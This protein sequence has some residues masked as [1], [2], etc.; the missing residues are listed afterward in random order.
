MNI[1]IDSL[2][3]L[4]HQIILNGPGLGNGF[5]HFA[6]NINFLID[7]FALNPQ[8]HEINAGQGKAEKESKENQIAKQTK[9][10][11]QKH[12]VSVNWKSVGKIGRQFHEREA[13]E[14]GAEKEQ[15][16]EKKVFR[17]KEV[18]V[19]NLQG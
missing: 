10:K 13:K 9:Q 2:G 3:V 11:E 7:G 12:F 4:D 14:N 6:L 19:E 5:F 17:S 8:G 16:P 18:F 15:K 1:N